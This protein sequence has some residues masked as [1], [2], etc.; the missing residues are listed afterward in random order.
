MSTMGEVEIEAT[1]AIAGEVDQGGRIVE[2]DALKA[3]VDGRRYFFQDDRLIFKG[4]L[5]EFP[6]AHHLVTLPA[7][8]IVGDKL[9][10]PDCRQ[11]S[12]RQVQDFL[13]LSPA[14]W[15]VID[16]VVIDRDHKIIARCGAMQAQTCASPTERQAN[17]LAIAALPALLDVLLFICAEDDTAARDDLQ[18]GGARSFLP[19][20]LRAEI[21]RALH[22]AKHGE[23]K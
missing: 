17:A 7:V 4:P 8:S 12:A 2:A 14:P 13:D 9:T 5:S 20:H 19:Y 16:D 6:R 11:P 21:E 1:I 15:A 10:A 3:M 18:S 22:C 23:P